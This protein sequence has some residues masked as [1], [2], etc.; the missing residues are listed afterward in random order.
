MC[1]PRTALGSPGSV[2]LEQAAVC[3]LPFGGVYVVRRCHSP[4]RQGMAKAGLDGAWGN[5]VWW[6][7]FLPKG[8]GAGWSSRS[9]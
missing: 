7:V 3:C 9:F 6:K 4:K 1:S 5:Q 2:I 8:G